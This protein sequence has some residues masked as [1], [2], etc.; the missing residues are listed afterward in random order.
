VSRNLPAG[1]DLA[2]E[3]LD[4]L[5][6]VPPG[7]G[8]I[9]DELTWSAEGDES[10]GA[11]GASDGPTRTTT[12]DKASRATPISAEALKGYTEAA[13]AIVAAAGGALNALDAEDEDDEIWLPTDVE[14]K[15]IGQPLGRIA[16]RHMPVPGGNADAGDV[17]DAITALVGLAVYATRNLTEKAR[18]FRRRR[19]LLK[20]QVLTEDQDGGQQ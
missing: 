11:D 17:A 7:M 15:A 12:S 5:P 2:P 8:P 6:G 10:G 14:E 3:E 9:E 19:R 1:E 4:E 20:G 13:K 18:R 16:A